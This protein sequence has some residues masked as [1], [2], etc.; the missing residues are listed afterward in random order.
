M[1]RS[2]HPVAFAIA[3]N[4]GHF[5]PTLTIVNDN[6]KPPDSELVRARLIAAPLNLSKFPFKKHNDGSLVGHS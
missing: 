2:T 6:F 1:L 4:W 3:S 5:A